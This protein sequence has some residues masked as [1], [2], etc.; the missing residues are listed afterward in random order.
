MLNA[1]GAA[2]LCGLAL[3]AVSATAVETFG[4]TGVGLRADG[5]T[6]PNMRAAV[7][8]PI[9]IELFLDLRLDLVFFV[10]LVMADSS[11][12]GSGEDLSV[13][14]KDQHT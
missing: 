14:W 10:F 2:A 7:G 13:L 3:A 11:S 4:G 5:N 1:F 9:A 6:E 8:K 12:S